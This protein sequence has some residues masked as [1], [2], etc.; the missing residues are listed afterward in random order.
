MLANTEVT[1]LF[2][3]AM[4]CMLSLKQAEICF[5]RASMF[6]QPSCVNYTF[7]AVNTST[8][9][10]PRDTRGGS[11]PKPATRQRKG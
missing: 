4:I 8:P 1:S 2:C 11:T 6:H 5:E 9:K 3:H 10:F 7:I